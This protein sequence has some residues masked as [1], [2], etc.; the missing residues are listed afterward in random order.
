MDVIVMITTKRT[1]TPKEEQNWRAMTP[2]MQQT[3]IE[4][5]EAVL[6]EQ[7]NGLGDGPKVSRVQVIYR[8]SGPRKVEEMDCPACDNNPEYVEWCLRCD[9][10]GKIAE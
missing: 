2:E 9:G 3:S 10:K 8:E 1:L 7:M 4:Y 6:R 5:S